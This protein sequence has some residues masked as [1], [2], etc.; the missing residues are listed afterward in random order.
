MTIGGAASMPITFNASGVMTAPAA[1][2]TVVVTLTNGASSPLSLTWDL[3][4]GS[5]ASATAT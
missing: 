2:V 3:F 5:P 1:D 4:D